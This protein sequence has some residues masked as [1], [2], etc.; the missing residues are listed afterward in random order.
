LTGC[1][2]DETMN[3][4]D[5]LKEQLQLLKTRFPEAKAALEEVEA[6]LQQ[7]QPEI[8]ADMRY[9]DYVSYWQKVNNQVVYQR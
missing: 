7:L 3:R 5:K 4:M 1:L 9:K 6:M 8:Q 2:I